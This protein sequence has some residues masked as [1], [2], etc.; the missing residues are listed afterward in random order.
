MPFKHQNKP[1]YTK[2]NHRPVPK[3]E[4]TDAKKDAQIA[5]NPMKT[6]QK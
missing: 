1:K 6:R 4:S 3:S 2:K 5:Q